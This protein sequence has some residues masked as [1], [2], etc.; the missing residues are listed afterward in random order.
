MTGKSPP[1]KVILMGLEP[2]GQDDSESWCDVHLLLPLMKCLRTACRIQ[3]EECGRW[4]L[5]K[6]NRNGCSALQ[7]KQERARCGFRFPNGELGGWG[8]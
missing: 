5:M 2:L 7:E 8:E 6:E 3:L 1:Q 4:F